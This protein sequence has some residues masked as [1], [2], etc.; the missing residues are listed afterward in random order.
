MLVLQL[1][2]RSIS[3]E[4]SRDSVGHGHA[5]VLEPPFEPIHSVIRRPLKLAFVHGVV[6]DQ[7]HVGDPYSSFTEMKTQFLSIG[8]I[9]ID[10]FCKPTHLKPI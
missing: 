5:L 1:S 2:A 9:V 7:I 8:F 4:T 3:V 10:S 6:T